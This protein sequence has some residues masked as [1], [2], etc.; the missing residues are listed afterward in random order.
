[1]TCLTARIDYSVKFIRKSVSLCVTL[2]ASN[3]LP[4]DRELTRDRG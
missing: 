2:H 4:A 1:M 3:C